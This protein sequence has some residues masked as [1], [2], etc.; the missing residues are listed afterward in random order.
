[1]RPSTA[2]PSDLFTATPTLSPTVYVH[3]VPR[4]TRQRFGGQHA[5]RIRLIVGIRLSLL[6]VPTLCLLLGIRLSV[7]GSLPPVP[8]L[9]DSSA[10]PTTSSPLAS[11]PTTAR[12]SPVLATEPSSSGTPLVTAST[13]SPTRATP[14]GL[15]ASASAPTPRT[16]LLSRP[17]GTSLSRLVKKMISFLAVFT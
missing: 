12:S 8:P 6:T 5:F 2:T 11:L 14:S 9:D 7:S 10:T 4:S 1:M 3:P 16:L 17:V 13:P 15:L